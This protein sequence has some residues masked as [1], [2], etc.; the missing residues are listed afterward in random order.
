MPSGLRPGFWQ[1]GQWN[2]STPLVWSR[3][4]ERPRSARSASTADAT[5]EARPPGAFRIPT[6][7]SAIMRANNF[8]AQPAAP[9]ERLVSSSLPLVAARRAS[10]PGVT[11]TVW[12]E[13]HAAVLRDRLAFE[14][15]CLSVS[16]CS[17]RSRDA[18]AEAGRRS[19]QVLCPATLSAYRQRTMSASHRMRLRGDPSFRKSG[20]DTSV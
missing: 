15:R 2:Q 18:F 14:S 6:D 7:R 19:S 16:F 9:P 3:R 5:N 20:S 4:R 17:R 10:T 11:A 8:S 13:R 12:Y 1:Q